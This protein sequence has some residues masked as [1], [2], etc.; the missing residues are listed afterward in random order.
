MLIHLANI[1]I[2]RPRAALYTY[3]IN[4]SIYCAMS[5]INENIYRSD[6]QVTFELNGGF[7]IHWV[8]QYLVNCTG[9]PGIVKTII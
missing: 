3:S 8:K 2:R 5:K 7:E 1:S 4:K 6:G 9:L